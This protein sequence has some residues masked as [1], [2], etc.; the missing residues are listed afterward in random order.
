MSVTLTVTAL[1]S[2]RM[3]VTTDAVTEIATSDSA[4]RLVV[5]AG[6][7]P[8]DVEIRVTKLDVESVGSPPG[9]QE[10]VVF[11]AEVDTF[12]AGS[13]TPTPMTYSRGVDLRFELP[14]G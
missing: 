4:V 1:P 12:A 14:E 9:A 2:V 10:R 3:P 5:P 7:A 11:A 8:A 6:A 13:N